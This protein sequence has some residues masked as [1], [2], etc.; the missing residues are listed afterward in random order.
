MVARDG[1]EPASQ[2]HRGTDRQRHSERV[3]EKEI[4]RDGGREVG[5]PGQDTASKNTPTLTYFL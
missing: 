4:G 3:R 5:R 1:R 2:T